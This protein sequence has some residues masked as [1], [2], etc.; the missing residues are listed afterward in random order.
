MNRLATLLVALPLFFVVPAH[1]QQEDAYDYWGHNRE[2]IQRG[3][4]AILMCNGLFTSNRTIEQVFD[5]ELKYVRNAAGVATEGEYEVDWDKKAVAIGTAGPVPTMRA[6]FRE[7]IGCVSMAP[8]QT[9]EGQPGLR[10]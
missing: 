1:A 7:G 5:Q 6:A 10:A 9:F 3:V 4:H 2:M 8:D